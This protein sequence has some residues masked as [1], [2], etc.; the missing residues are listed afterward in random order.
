[1]FLDINNE[2]SMKLF[3]Q[4]LGSLLNGGEVVELIGD[5]G[6]GK[7]TL[8]KG[9]AT[10]L[11]VLDYIQSP[12]F[13][14]NRVYE[15]RDNLKLSH[16]DFYRLNDAGLMKDDLDEVMADKD[17]VTVIEWA[18][19]VSNILPEDRLSIKIS[20]VSENS[21]RLEFISGGPNSSK[22]MEMLKR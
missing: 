5:V 16:Y 19:L 7:T 21:R 9:V 22:L 17:T 18:G 2:N 15:C 11:G 1:M 12:S 6:A 4:K 13:T 14:I 8:V 20:L 3:G 10:G